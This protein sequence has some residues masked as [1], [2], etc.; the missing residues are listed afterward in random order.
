MAVRLDSV[1]HNTDKR[2]KQPQ[3]LLSHP[4]LLHFLPFHAHLSNP[5]RRQGAK[6]ASAHLTRRES[7]AQAR[8]LLAQR[9]QQLLHEALPSL[10]HM[11]ISVRVCARAR[12]SK[13]NRC[14]VRTWGLEPDSNHEE[15]AAE[16]PLFFC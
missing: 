14:I 8:Q 6:E 5:R 13:S 2:Q 4:Q 10:C 1:S 11:H 16:V 15:E 3:H 12:T 9:H 7:H